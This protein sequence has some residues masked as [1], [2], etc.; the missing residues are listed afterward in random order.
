MSDSALK[1]VPIPA[2]QPERPEDDVHLTLW[3]HI[4]ELRKRMV[5]SAYGFGV[6]VIIC[7]HFYDKIFDWLKRPI[8]DALVAFAQKRCPNP[9]VTCP[10][11]LRS[12]VLVYHNPTDPIFVY[13]RIACY[14]GL[15][16]AA[17]W[18]LYQFWMFVSPG[19]YR[20]ERKLVAPFVVLGSIFFVGG[21]AFARYVI[22]PFAFDVLIGQTAGDSLQP[23]L[24]ITECTDLVVM[25]LLA[26]GIIFELPLILTLLARVGLVTSAFLSKY[27]RHAIV[28]NTIIAAIITPTGDPFNLMLM[29]VP[30]VVFYELGIIGAKFAE[31]RRAAANALPA[32]AE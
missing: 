10:E 15:F 9:L 22:M 32:E 24:G 1:L 6:G 16:V 8:V 31:R 27:R 17:P 14:A 23:M 28:L 18:I 4:R 2:P 7:Y 19:L 3:D 30:L 11:A 13:I 29:A 12:G 20:R 25:M 21:G 5:L 26:F